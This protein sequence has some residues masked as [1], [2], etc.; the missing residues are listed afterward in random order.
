MITVLGLVAGVLT[1]ASWLPQLR[2]SWRTRSTGDLSWTYLVMLSV[3][4]GL[5]LTYGVAVADVAVLAANALTLAAL[6]TLMVLK[7]VHHHAPGEAR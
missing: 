7:V 4:V 1:T 3:G 2:R 5:W 6:T